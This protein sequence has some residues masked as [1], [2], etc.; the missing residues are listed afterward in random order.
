MNRTKTSPAAHEWWKAAPLALIAFA[1]MAAPISFWFRT[2]DRYAVFL[3]EHLGAGPFSPVTVG[4]YWMTGLVAG[5]ILLFLNLAVN[6]ASGWNA[7]R[8][9]EV[10]VVADW[11][12]AWLLAAPPTAYVI[13]WATLTQNTPT[14]P[15]PLAMI[16]TVVALAAMALALAPA[17][18]AAHQPRTLALLALV[19]AGL[20]PILMTAHAV[21]LSAIGLLTTRTA[22]LFAAGGLLVSLLWMGVARL[23]LQRR[24]TPLPTLWKVLLAGCAWSYLALPLVHYLFFTP[25]AYRYI[26]AS[27]NYFALTLPMQLL[28]WALAIAVAM[29]ASDVP[30]RPRKSN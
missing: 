12:R 28:T 15:W 1:A 6:A 11:R 2:A 26:T 14:L 20:V 13:L 19:G 22:W 9:G 18:M 8:Y 17:R 16:V 30:A 27:A 5:G 3:Y 4:R 23:W 25:A 21:E 24:R 7:R 29:I 10:Y